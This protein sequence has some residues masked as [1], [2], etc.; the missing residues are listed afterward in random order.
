ML[1]VVRGRTA[2]LQQYCVVLCSTVMVI[3]V[4]SRDPAHVA[5]VLVTLVRA[6][7]GGQGTL[8]TALPSNH[9]H[10]NN[11]NNYLLGDFSK[12]NEIY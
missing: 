12:L 4:L 10:H 7:G 1:D 6:C 5:A 8:H 11:T 2:V 9:T 3:S